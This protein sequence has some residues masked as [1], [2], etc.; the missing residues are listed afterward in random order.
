M[1][2][3]SP[4]KYN[5]INILENNSYFHYGFNSNQGYQNSSLKT[6]NPI[7]EPLEEIKKL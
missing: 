1:E 7:K 5:I 4:T 2:Y 3:G 6:E